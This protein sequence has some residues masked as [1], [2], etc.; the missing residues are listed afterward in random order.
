[1]SL[2]NVYLRGSDIV[3]V[4]TAGGGGLYRDI[5]PV[6][7][8][9]PSAEAVRGAI[10]EARAAASRTDL[11][12]QTK[13]WVVL[14]RLRLKSNKAF[15]VDVTCCTVHDD[16]Q[17]RMIVSRYRPAPDG[18]GFEPEGTETVVDVDTVAPTVL[19]VLQSS[20]RFPK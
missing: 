4:P 8:V 13:R 3:V 2:I 12:V 16:E 19:D 10:I 15:Y 6:L 1:M 17:G 20:T 18:Q 9:A 7:V 5:P 14:E 11:P